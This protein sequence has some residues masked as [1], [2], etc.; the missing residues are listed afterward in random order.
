MSSFSFC[1]DRMLS[2]NPAVASTTLN[3]MFPTLPLRVEQTEGSGRREWTCTR[4]SRVRL[5]WNMGWDK[6]CWPLPPFILPRAECSATGRLDSSV[7]FLIFWIQLKWSL[8]PGSNKFV[9]DDKLQDVKMCA[10]NLGLLLFIDMGFTHL[11]CMQPNMRT[12]DGDD[13]GQKLVCWTGGLL[14]SIFLLLAC[15]CLG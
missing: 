8:Q 15:K 14:V 10:F 9:V 5:L 7:D 3:C 11:E 1:F 13:L 2:I 12:I 6:A 4:I